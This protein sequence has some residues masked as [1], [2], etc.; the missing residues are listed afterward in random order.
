[1]CA[2]GMR[3]YIEGR[4]TRSGLGRDRTGDVLQVSAEKGLD[5]KLPRGSCRPRLDTLLT[6]SENLG[7]TVSELIEGL[8]HEKGMAV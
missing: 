5:S 6:I 1:V 8:A 7:V 3:I 4:K 2:Y